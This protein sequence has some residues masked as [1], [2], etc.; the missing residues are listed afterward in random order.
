MAKSHVSHA[1]SLW[2]WYKKGIALRT[3]TGH[4][5]PHA[6]GTRHT[7]TASQNC[8]YTQA[9]EKILGQLNLMAPSRRPPH[10]PCRYTPDKC[11]PTSRTSDTPW[12]MVKNLWCSSWDPEFQMWF[13]QQHWED[14]P[15]S[16][17]LCWRTMEE[18][19]PSQLG[20]WNLLRLKRDRQIKHEQRLKVSREAE[21]QGGAFSIRTWAIQ[22]AVSALKQGWAAFPHHPLGLQ[23]RAEAGAAFLPMLCVAASPPPLLNS[24][25][26]RSVRRGMD[27]SRKDCE[28]A[29]YFYTTG[30]R[31]SLPKCHPNAPSPAKTMSALPSRV[32]LKGGLW[33]A[34]NSS[35]WCYH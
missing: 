28:T 6:A 19:S 23:Q 2:C 22:K 9:G 18:C 25:C 17:S 1:P 20:L 29:P 12:N 16:R 8:I 30:E 31:G 21:E 11:I 27:F 7:Y 35:V 3:E 10:T 4:I 34:I 14:R 32:T 13:L 15:Q 33:R 5:S 24:P 26:V